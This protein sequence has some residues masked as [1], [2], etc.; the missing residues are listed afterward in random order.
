MVASYLLESDE[1]SPVTGTDIDSAV[2]EALEEGDRR[3]A[4]EV[5]IEA[6]GREIYNYIRR[7]VRAE[8]LADD[9]FQDF[10]LDL[11]DGWEQ[12]AWEST[13]KTWAYS[14]ARNA[15]HRLL[16]AESSGNRRRLHTD[17]QEELAAEWTR[18]TTRNWEKTE[19]RK[20]LWETV[21]EFDPEDR[22]LLVLRLGNQMEWSEV[23]RVVEDDDDLDGD[24]LR[25]ASAR[26]RKRFQRLKE[27]LRERRDEFGG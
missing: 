10:A 9:A 4:T 20:W 26:L 16:R 15:T 1:E 6:Y 11:L 23:A 25:R 19:A 3:R 7:T 2:R 5:A 27:N 8:H 21:E 22:E 12:F 14:V 24:A 13:V 17:E 18:T